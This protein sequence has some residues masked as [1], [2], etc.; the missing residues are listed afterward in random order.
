[1]SEEETIEDQIEKE[2]EDLDDEPVSEDLE[3][4]PEPEDLEGE[5]EPEKDVPKRPKK[6]FIATKKGKL[7]IVFLIIGIALAIGLWGAAP[8][9]Y[10]SLEEVV[11]NSDS[12]MGKEIEVIGKVGNWTG[13]Q[14]FTL[15][16]RDNENLT[17]Y[18]VHEKEIPDGFAIGKDVVVKGKLL[19]GD[20]ELI[21]NSNH[22]IQVGCPSKY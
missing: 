17:I 9:D 3:D 22:P 1:M 2:L 11:T 5:S 12:Y 10:L 14:N 4:E 18:V 8:G 19:D 15:V 13:G 7:L 16:G 20:G 6:R 21:L